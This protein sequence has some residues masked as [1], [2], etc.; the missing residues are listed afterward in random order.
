MRDDFGA[1]SNIELW[2]RVPRPVSDTAFLGFDLHDRRNIGKP[3]SDGIRV[4]R[5]HEYSEAQDLT[6]LGNHALYLWLPDDEGE[7]RT[8]IAKVKVFK[9]CAWCEECGAD[10]DDLATHLFAEH[11]DRL[12][13]RLVL[14]G[15][16]A[17]SAERKSGLVCLAPGC[18]ESYPE[19]PL[20]EERAFTLLDHHCNKWHGGRMSYMKVYSFHDLPGGQEK[21]IWKCKLDSSHAIIPPPDDENAVADKTAH[22]KEHLSELLRQPGL[23]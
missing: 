14:R 16:G 22:L 10:P 7:K 15:P 8:E 12:F 2:I 1:T 11:H 23:R 21:W 9:K 17:S 5:L 20:P 3:K 19:S 4:I 18:G 13:E 6:R